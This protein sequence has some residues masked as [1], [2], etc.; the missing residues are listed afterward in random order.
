[1]VP[2]RPCSEGRP[3]AIAH[4]RVGAPGSAAPHAPRLGGPL[5]FFARVAAHDRLISAS[6]NTPNALP[7]PTRLSPTC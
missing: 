1:M 2:V 6:T 4:I 5:H 3:F 7:L